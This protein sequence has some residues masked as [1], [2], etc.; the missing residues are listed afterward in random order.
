M[1]LWGSVPWRGLEC[2]LLEGRREKRNIK[3]SRAQRVAETNRTHCEPT[4]TPTCLTSPCT[5]I[6]ALRRPH[7]Q[8]WTC[9]QKR[10][11]SSR[12]RRFLPGGLHPPSLSLHWPLW[13]AHGW[14][15]FTRRRDLA[16]LSPHVADRSC[17]HMLHFKCD[18]NEFVSLVDWN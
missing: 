5:W 2:V 17:Q 4:N 14:D 9:E 15:N 13:E 10:R 1:G 11:V 16:S 18:R 12:P 6:G 8:Q 7:L 3:P